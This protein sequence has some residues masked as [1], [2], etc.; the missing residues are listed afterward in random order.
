[1]ASVSQRAAATLLVCASFVEAAVARLAHPNRPC[2]AALQE[3]DVGTG[4]G[5]FEVQKIGEEFF[6]FIVDCQVGRHGWVQG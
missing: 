5:L 2:C 4:A 1:M 6:T 3:S